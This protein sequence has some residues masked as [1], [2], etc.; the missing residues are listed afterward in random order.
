MGVGLRL[1]NRQL[2]KLCC[3]MI[4]IAGSVFVLLLGF[5]SLG[6]G[7]QILRGFPDRNLP[8]EVWTGVAT[9][10]S[11]FVAIRNIYRDV[12]VS[13][14]KFRPKDQGPSFSHYE[15][16]VFVTKEPGWLEAKRSRFLV[17]P[18]SKLNGKTRSVSDYT[19][20]TNTKRKTIL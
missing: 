20:W 3:V 6:S 1:R 19:T 10:F 2:F 11:N 16:W 12:W 5:V 7:L 15:I 17:P 9:A 4:P 14:R 8:Y 18:L 13:P